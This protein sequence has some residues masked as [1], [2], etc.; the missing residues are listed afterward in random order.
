MGNPTI[1]TAAG[2]VSA[3]ALASMYFGAVMVKPRD[4]ATG[5]GEGEDISVTSS[6]TF[7]RGHQLQARPD[8]GVGKDYWGY[9]SHIPSHVLVC[10]CPQPP[11]DRPPSR[12][13]TPRP[14]D[15][16]TRPRSSSHPPPTSSS[17]WL[18]TA[19]RCASP[20]SP[21][22]SSRPSAPSLSGST[23]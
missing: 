7:M 1:L 12:T 20:F 10:A 22:P 23:S 16:Q 18:S 8:Y 6:G 15:V 17:P 13:P 14:R 19:T 3:A 11:P 9:M 5:V 4:V 2:V 21:A